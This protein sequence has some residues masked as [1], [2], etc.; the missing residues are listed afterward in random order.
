MRCALATASRVC[1]LLGAM[2]INKILVWGIPQRSLTWSGASSWV[3]SSWRRRW[4][5]PTATD[6]MA[7]P[8]AS[9]YYS[10]EYGEIMW[11]RP[12]LTR[13]EP[14]LIRNGD[15]TDVGTDQRQENRLN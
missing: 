4:P 12:P 5:A 11:S 3:N 1:K 13:H 7:P 2:A 8:L 10:V 15:S 9:P 14:E 6:G